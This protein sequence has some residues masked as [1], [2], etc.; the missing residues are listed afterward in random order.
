ME[1]ATPLILPVNAPP[2]MNVLPLKI[3]VF[4]PVQ[5]LAPPVVV[6]LGHTVVVF[7]STLQC[8]LLVLLTGVCMALLPHPVRVAQ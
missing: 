5:L 3:N 4:K 1:L 6:R 7:L 2:V 8:I